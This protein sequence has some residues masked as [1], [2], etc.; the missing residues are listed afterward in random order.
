[1]SAEDICGDCSADSVNVENI[2]E[3]ELCD[4]EN[5]TATSTDYQAKHSYVD[6]TIV[7]GLSNSSS[8]ENTVSY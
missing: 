4:T 6:C 8:L 7:T 3:P 2:C 5:S 1:M